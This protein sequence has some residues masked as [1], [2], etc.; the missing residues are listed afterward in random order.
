MFAYQLKMNKP[1]QN[2]F[3]MNPSFNTI[4]ESLDDLKKN[5][6]SRISYKTDRRTDGPTDGH[7]RSLRIC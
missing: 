2:Q 7:C 4:V 1:T 5:P 6:V 3:W